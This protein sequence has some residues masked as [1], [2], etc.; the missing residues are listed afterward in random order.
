MLS[1]IEGKNLLDSDAQALVNA[2][3]CVG[4][5]G[6]GLARQFRAAFPT[7]HSSYVAACASG[8]VAPGVL[9]TF[10]LPN[11]RWI[12]NF[13]TKRHW[14]Q[15][16]RVEDVEAGLV[17]LAAWIEVHGIESI[18]VPALGCSNGGLRWSS[19]QPRIEAVF[20]ELPAVRVELYAPQ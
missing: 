7:M 4:V 12:V 13:P 15:A 16:S 9:H 18:A 8:C 20:S 14:R 2:V 5:M 11:D 17:A 3:N 19:I 6:K 10:S 1:L